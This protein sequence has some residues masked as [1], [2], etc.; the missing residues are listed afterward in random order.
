VDKV[1]IALVAVLA[2]G[3]IFIVYG[4][5]EPAVVNAGDSAPDFK[6]VTEDGNTITP[7]S[8]P[9]KL[10]VLNFWASWCAPCVE[11]TPSLNEFQ[12]AM[13]PQGVIVLAVSVDK[14]EKLY[15]Q[16]LQR[17][18]VVFKTSRDPNADIP[19]MYGTFQFPDSYIIDPKGR[20]VEKIINAQNWMDPQFIAHIQKML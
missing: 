15:H 18:N 11:E 14:N 8:F 6:V 12:R 4:T 2:A 3:L 19:T 16:F 20:V 1:L 5:L 13:A 9:G 7:S 17:F 10:L